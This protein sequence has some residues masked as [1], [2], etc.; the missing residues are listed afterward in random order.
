MSHSLNKAHQ[1]QLV[2]LIQNIC[3]QCRCASTCPGQRSGTE[4]FR[5]RANSLPGANRPIGPWPIRS[6]ELSLPGPFAPWPFRSLAFSLP[7]QFAPWP[8]RTQ[9]FSLPGTKV[10]WNFRS[11][12]LSFPGTFAL[13]MCL[14][15]F[16]VLHLHSRPTAAPVSVSSTPE[17]SRRKLMSCFYHLRRL[18]SVRRQLGRDVTA[19]LVSAFVLSRLDYC[20]VVLPSLPATTLAP[21]QRVLHA[22]ARLVVDL[23]PRDHVSQALQHWLPIDKR[24]DYKL[25]VLVHKASI[26]QAPTYIADMLTPVSSVQSLSTQRSATNG[27]YIVPRS[28]HI[29]SLARGLSQSPYLKLGTG[30]RPNWKRQPVPLIVLNALSKHFYFS[31][32][33][34]MKHV[35]ADF[36]NA[37]SVRL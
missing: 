25:C 26:G 13:L 1:V 8:F 3:I 37:P 29:A 22:A 17:P 2:A 14:S 27:D 7:G 18:R 21:L 36:C 34:A 19:R 12:E 4:P 31:L 5:S 28:L 6:L 24:I 11:L 35:L 16:A 30:C 10:L 20:N 23:R 33:T 15:I 9:A 32:P